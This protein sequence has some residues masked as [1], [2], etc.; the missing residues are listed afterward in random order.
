MRITL[1]FTFTYSFY[2]G[3][4]YFSRNKLFGGIIVAITETMKQL[5]ER[6]Q[7]LQKQ[8]NDII[9]KFTEAIKATWPQIKESY[10]KISQITI[11]IIDAAS[12]LAAT[13]LKA[14]LSIINEHQKELKELATV[15]AE[16]AQDIAKII[17][18][19]ASQIEKD[20]KDFVVLL[21]QQLKALPIYDMIKD[22]YQNI[23]DYQI[24]QAMLAPIE[25]LYV[26]IRNILPTEELKELFA[27]TFNYIMKHIKRE[28]VKFTID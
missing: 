26:N 1:K 5:I 14:I 19:A 2:Y 16:L 12:N 23:A 27:A 3:N 20:V 7:D 15:T 9:V 21:I 6:L 25:E 4:E 18:K 22:K 8:L 10:Q 13:Y 24:P 11:E 28:K 17:F